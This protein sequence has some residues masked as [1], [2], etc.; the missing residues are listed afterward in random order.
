M[1]RNQ[2]TYPVRAMCRAL[3]LSASG[4]YAWS[5]RRPSALAQRDEELTA[6][7]ETVWK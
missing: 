5:G 6:K 7:I 3:G 1:K 4:Y 2:A